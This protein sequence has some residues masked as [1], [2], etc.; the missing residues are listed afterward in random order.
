MHSTGLIILMVVKLDYAQM[1]VLLTSVKNSWNPDHFYT[2]DKPNGLF[3]TFSTIATKEVKN[4]F[5]YARYI[6]AS[7]GARPPYGSRFFRFDMQNFWNVA[8]SGVHGPPYEVHAPPTGNP[9]SATALCLLSAGTFLSG[10]EDNMCHYLPQQL[11][12]LLLLLTR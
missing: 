10:V 6:G 4:C 2:T 5:N 7:R 9:G 12:L 1:N 3:H 8:A 11:L